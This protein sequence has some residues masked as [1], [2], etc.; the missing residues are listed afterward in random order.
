M[1][2]L[3][4]LL[5][6][7]FSAGVIPLLS[8]HATAQEGE[9]RPSVGGDAEGPGYYA[10]A[11]A[12]EDLPPQLPYGQI[13]EAVQWL[14]RTAT[15]V[16]CRFTDYMHECGCWPVRGADKVLFRAL[17]N[18]KE[19][20]RHARLASRRGGIGRPQINQLAGAARQIELILDRREI[21]PPEID[22][23][24]QDALDITAFLAGTVIVPR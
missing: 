13:V 4:R 22:Q 6:A 18:F 17:C 15:K 19:Q 1:H 24:I 14:D 7:V 10:G 11:S 16:H 2:V 20:A 3:N 5:I 23:P 8:G 21:L 12:D 9:F